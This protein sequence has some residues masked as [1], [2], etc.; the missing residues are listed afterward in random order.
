MLLIIAIL[1]KNGLDLRFF[2][3]IKMT[4]ICWQNKT[5]VRNQK[6]IHKKYPL[7]QTEKLL[8]WPICVSPSTI[9]HM[10]GFPKRLIHRVIEIEI[11]LVKYLQL[12]NNITIH[13]RVVVSW[14][15][16]WSSNSSSN[17][18]NVFIRPA[19]F[20]FQQS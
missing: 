8:N 9:T 1:S 15:H 17:R 7:F 6:T 2:A 3:I 4:I 19:K 14:E 13:M 10:D 12:F 5:T 16:K 20:M 18:N 11:S